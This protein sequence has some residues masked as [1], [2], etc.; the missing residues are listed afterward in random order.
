MASGCRGID[1]GRFRS[2]AEAVAPLLLILA[3]FYLGCRSTLSE[4]RLEKETDRG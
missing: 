3:A 1:T 4:Y 2:D